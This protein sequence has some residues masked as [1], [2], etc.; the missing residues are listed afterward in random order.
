MRYH[1]E[2]KHHFSHFAR[3]PGSLDWANQPDPFRRYEGAPLFALPRLK[4][5]DAPPS[6]LYED[7]YRPGAIASVSVNVRS[8]SRLFEYSLAISAWKQAGEVRWALRSN[9]S[10]GNLHPTEG[11]L[12]I[13]DVAGLS[14]G[15]GLYHY[16]AKEHALELRAQ[17]PKESFMRLLQG[18]PPEAFLVGFAS[19][20]WR[21]TWKYGERAFRYCQHDVGHAIGSARIAAQTLGWRMLLLDGLA[22]DTVAALLGVDRAEDFEGAERE[23]PDCLAVV[24]PDDQ[25]AGR[26]TSTTSCMPL[27]LAADA[28]CDVTTTYLAR[29]G[30]PAESRR[31]G[32]ME[33]P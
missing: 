4:P 19:V 5:D 3:A 26:A 33:D 17:W 12:L 16:A 29:Q 11:Y 7:L 25:A 32:A 18:F 15:P 28:V 24:W 6:P 31:S 20:N 10:S 14:P 21:E 2:T 13:D 9:P 23:H 8:L 22:D 30:K 1:Q 27:F